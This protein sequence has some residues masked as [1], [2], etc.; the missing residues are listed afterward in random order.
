V[1]EP[2]ARV[3]VTGPVRRRTGPVVRSDAAAEIDADT[4]LGDLYLQSLLRSQLRLAAAVIGGLLLSLGS[5]P[6][7]FHLVPSLAQSTVAGVPIGFAALGFLAYPVLL[8]LAAAYVWLAE[9]NEAA[10]VA[11]LE[12]AAD[13]GPDG[14]P[15][16]RPDA[17]PDDRAGAEAGER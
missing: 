4:V 16:A 7:L 1:T 5:L 12:R 3:R 13:A 14:G 2:Q 9:R 8:A 11:L 6:L 10:F 17:G 15:D